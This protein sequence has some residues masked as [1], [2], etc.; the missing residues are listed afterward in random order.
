V[1]LTLSG[2]T[3][4]ICNGI[5]GNDAIEMGWDTFSI[6]GPIAAHTEVSAYTRARPFTPVSNDATCIYNISGEF[7]HSVPGV[8]YTPQ[9][10]THRGEGTVTLSY[11]TATFPE[12]AETV[13]THTTAGWYLQ[14][15]TDYAGGVQ[16][17][18]GDDAIPAGS[19][20]NIWLTWICRGGPNQTK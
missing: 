11:A 1:A 15:V 2:T 7:L 9:L 4:Y 14:D 6:P 16:L 3:S 8:T 12:G 17:N 13:Q 19:S 20:V 18:V 10:R 5:S